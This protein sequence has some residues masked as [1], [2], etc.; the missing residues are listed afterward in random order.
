MSHTYYGSV[1]DCYGSGLSLAMMY[2]FCKH[3]R[4]IGL[5]YGWSAHIKRLRTVQPLD[6]TTCSPAQPSTIGEEETILHHPTLLLSSVQ[7]KPVILEALHVGHGFCVTTL[8]WLWSNIYEWS[9]QRWVLNML[10]KPVMFL[11]NLRHKIYI[12]LEWKERTRN[13][14]CPVLK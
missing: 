12:H 8:Q 14:W 9:F 10:S 5:P 4:L 6:S 2:K 11:N 3:K 1:M 13:Y 7:S